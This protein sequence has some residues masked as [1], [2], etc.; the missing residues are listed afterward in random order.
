[1][2]AV[3]KASP[4]PGLELSEVSIPRLN[5]G[6]VLIK[7][8]ATALCGTDIHIYDWNAWAQN[9]NLKLPLIVGHECAGE[10]AELGLNVNG[11]SIGDRV[12]VETHIPCGHCLQCQI[13]E[14]H[15]CANLKIF[16]VHVN[17]CFAEYA[18]VPAICVR[19]IPDAIS[20]QVGAILEPLGTAFRSITEARVTGKSVVIIGCGPIGLFAIASAVMAGAAHII[21]LDIS[22]FRLAGAKNMGATAVFDSTRDD[23]IE[24]ILQITHGYGADVIIDASGSVIAI[25]SAFRYL[26][27]G[28]TLGLI[29]L[30]GRPIELEL[31]SDVVFKEAKIFGIHGRKMFETWYEMEGALASGRLNIDPV[32]SHEL[33]LAQ[34]DKAIELSKQG[35]ANKVILIP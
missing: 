6:E 14:Q 17:G 19:K 25:K 15:I 2:Q 21:A 26:R 5:P 13:G 11:L 20:F 33:P 12:S 10:I 22:A 27:K 30:P 16:G 9:N 3:I 8:K 18:V 35:V 7:V 29:G 34:Y 24:Q 32:L 31:G 23:L 28:G 4:A 1:M